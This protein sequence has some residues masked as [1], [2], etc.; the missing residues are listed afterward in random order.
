MKRPSE[1]EDD[2]T[3]TLQ[4]LW[5]GYDGLV[6]P[7]SM[8]SALLVYQ[9]VWDRRIVHDYGRVP[10]DVQS[11]VLLHDGRVLPARRMLTD[12]RARWSAWQAPAA[13]QEASAA[14][15]LNQSDDQDHTASLNED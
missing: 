2:D 5:L 11:V 10:N 12:L 7:F 9:P 3:Y 1:A 13:D 6:V 15:R 8:I 4:E 14:G